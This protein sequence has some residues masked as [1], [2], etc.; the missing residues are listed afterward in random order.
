MLVS[1]LSGKFVVSTSFRLL[2]L[3]ETVYIPLCGRHNVCV[4]LLNHSAPVRK[5][6]ITI[7]M[8][9]DLDTVLKVISRRINK[10]CNKEFPDLA[11]DSRMRS[12]FLQ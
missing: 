3:H 11:H 2:T 12:S 1:N 9:S 5:D 4:T 6:S 10:G 8:H 7:T